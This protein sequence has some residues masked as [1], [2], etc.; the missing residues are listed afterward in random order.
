MNFDEKENLKFVGD[1]DLITTRRFFYEYYVDADSFVIKK[2]MNFGYAKHFHKAVEIYYILEGKIEAE[3]DGEKVLAQEGEIII[4]NGLEM[5]EYKE[6]SQPSKVIVMIVS[7]FYLELFESVYKNQIFPNHMQDIKYNQ[8][9]LEYME[10]LYEKFG[11]LS[12]LERKGYVALILGGL[13]KHYGVLEKKKHNDV[14]LNVMDYIFRNYKSEITLDLIARE[15]NYATNSI[16]RIFSK[17]IGVD[18]RVYVSNVRA[19]KAKQMLDKSDG[20]KTI[21][22]IAYDCGFNSMASFYRAYKRRYGKLPKNR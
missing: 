22:Q 1:I 5:H 13:A 19:E 6:S 10:G 9:L 4:V 18:F 21:M 2:H 17:N 14:V 3:I 15:F 12:E 20:T 11:E 7:S 8:T 16:S